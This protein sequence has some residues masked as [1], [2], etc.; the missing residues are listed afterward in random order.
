MSRWIQFLFVAICGLVKIYTKAELALLPQKPARTSTYFCRN[1]AGETVWLTDYDGDSM[2]DFVER[3]CKT[4]T[5]RKY[6]KVRCLE[7]SLVGN[8]PR[9]RQHFDATQLSDEAVDIR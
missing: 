9:V 4:P 2:V 8:A 5:V 6:S 1:E 7:E 3:Q